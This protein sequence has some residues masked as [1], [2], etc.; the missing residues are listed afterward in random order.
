MPLALINSIYF[1]GE[2]RL[3]SE[4][5]AVVGY[6]A[7]HGSTVRFRITSCGEPSR[8]VDRV[9]DFNL[10]LLVVGFCFRDFA[11]EPARIGRKSWRFSHRHDDTGDANGRENCEQSRGDWRTRAGNLP[12]CDL[13]ARKTFHYYRILVILATLSVIGVFPYA[14][15]DLR[16]GSCRR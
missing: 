2:C 15:R 11:R 8:F 4:D 9:V 16:I 10:A 7:L 12:S 1:R 5:V 6:P 3:F 13:L 14:Q